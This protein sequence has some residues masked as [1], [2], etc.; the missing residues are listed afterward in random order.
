MSD[1]K[2]MW[3]E[4]G[5]DLVAHDALLSILGGAYRDIF[6]SQKNRPEG[7]KYF[8]CIPIEAFLER[9]HKG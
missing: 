2:Q 6:L 4:L 1:Y 3:S 8:D 7:M 5:L 9:I